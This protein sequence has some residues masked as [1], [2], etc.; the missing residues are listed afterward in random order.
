VVRFI[1]FVFEP[2]SRMSMLNPLDS[3]AHDWVFYSA[4]RL[5]VKLI[6]REAEWVIHSAN[7]HSFGIFGIHSF[8]LLYSQE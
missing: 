1:E 8:V 4:D 7:V 3:R 5:D 2:F 6:E